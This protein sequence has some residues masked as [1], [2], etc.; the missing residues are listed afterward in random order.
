MAVILYL[1]QQEKFREYLLQIIEKAIPDH[2]VETFS[3]IGELSEKLHQ[4][5]PDVS[6]AVLYATNHAELMMIIYLGDLLGERR[7]VLVLPD[8][9]PDMLEKAYALRP[10]FIAAAQSDFKHLGIV[11]KKMA[12]LHNKRPL[13]SKK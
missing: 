12:D 1:P 10:Q 11:L 9:Q 5:M 8:D 13:V 4:A 3:S 7:I 6:V 2:T